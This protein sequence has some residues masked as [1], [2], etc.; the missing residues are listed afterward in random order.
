VHKVGTYGTYADVD[1]EVK[2]EHN[3]NQR[4]RCSVYNTI[5][6]NTIQY[7]TIQYKMKPYV[8][9]VLTSCRFLIEC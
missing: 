9:Q 5:Q 2:L 7:N 6:Y 1:V 4:Y 8:V 3:E